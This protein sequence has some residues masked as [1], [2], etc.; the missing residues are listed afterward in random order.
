MTQPGTTAADHP[1][2]MTHREVLAVLSGLM[3]GMFLAALDQSIVGTA[4]R[5]IVTDLGGADQASWVVAAYLITSTVTTPVYGKLSDLYGRKPVYQFAIGVFL[6]GSVLAGFSQNMVMLILAR[7][8]QGLGGGGLLSLAFT[9]IG[10][11]V[12]PRERGR[13]QGYFGA[14]F[15][16]SSVAG[17]LLGG[18]FTDTI[19]WHWIFFVNV[20]IGVLAWLVVGARLNL[21]FTRREHHIDYLGAVTLVAGVSA[22]LLVTQWGGQ[23][24]AWTSGPILG[25]SAAAVLL[26]AA[27]LLV[28]RRSP[29]PILPLRLF[30]NRT[31]S[32]VNAAQFII[33][34][35]MFGAIIYVPFYLQIVRGQSATEAGL[36]MIAVMVGILATSIASGLLIS[37]LGRWKPFPVAGTA[38]FTVGLALMATMT[39]TTSLWALGAYL[40]VIGAGLG[41]AM[42]TLILAVQN[43]SDP[44]E[45][46]V[47][48][49][50]V[51]FSRSLGGA[52][53]TAIFG[54][55]VTAGTTTLPGTDQLDPVAYTGAVARGFLVAV[56][57]GVLAFVL[58]ALLRNTRLRGSSGLV[59]Q[60]EQ[61]AAQRAVAPPEAAA[62]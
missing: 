37:R 11:M 27:F 35:G 6:L 45:L 39:T 55:I 53:G 50:S 16:L 43:D 1:P 28:E 7:A 20:P 59:A 30:R 13:Y 26:L 23:E 31:F 32:L 34:L 60:A 57:L 61:R 41:L 24:Y 12:S 49:S 8:V 22:A 44:G 19:G 48:T 9:I 42:Q 14:V 47:A 36:L 52:L 10:D 21:P 25:L 40:A 58:V 46:G 15:G 5:T 54:A 29:E 3:I 56:P 33:A 51:A 4:L 17:P 62:A 38:V 18:L 2:A